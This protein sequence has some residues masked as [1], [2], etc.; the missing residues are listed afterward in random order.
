MVRKNARGFDSQVI[1]C[2]SDVGLWPII[3]LVVVSFNFLL[4]FFPLLGEEMILKLTTQDGFASWKTHPT[5]VEKK[6][7]P[8]SKLLIKLLPCDI[9]AIRVARD[10][11][12]FPTNWGAKEPQNPQNHRI[13]YEKR[14]KTQLFV[15]IPR[16]P[17]PRVSGRDGPTKIDDEAIGTNLI[18]MRSEKKKTWLCKL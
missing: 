1:L 17:S 6:K 4:C 5:R 15:A 12:S 18:K 7:H 9:G 8:T 14:F 10:D 11:S 3:E 13:D 16:H 2:N